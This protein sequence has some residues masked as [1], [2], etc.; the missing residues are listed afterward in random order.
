MKKQVKAWLPDSGW[1][2]RPLF[3]GMIAGLLALMSVLP[4]Q[5][6]IIA[7]NDAVPA[8]MS[9]T[10]GTENDPS[11]Y[12][13]SGEE[14]VKNFGTT[15]ISVGNVA[16]ANWVRLEITGGA[17][18]WAT[19]ASSAAYIGS[20]SSS[21]TNLNNSVWVMD[22]GS[23]LTLGATRLGGKSALNTLAVVDGG[24]L[25]L[26]NE[27]RAGYENTG[28]YSTNNM[29][30]VD[31]GTLF[32]NNRLRLGY[33]VTHDYCSLVVRNGGKVI[34]SATGRMGARSGNYTD[35]RVEGE[36][37]E[38]EL[39]YTASSAISLGEAGSPHH[40]TLTIIDGG[41][42]KLTNTSGTLTIAVDPNYGGSGV[43]FAAGIF[44]VAGNRTTH[45]TYDKAW[46]WDG[47]AWEQ[48]PV[49]WTGTYYADETEAAAA[50]RPGY[51]GYTVFTG[52]KSMAGALK[53]TLLLL[54]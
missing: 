22:E 41:V 21:F 18:V 53:R 9:D 11:I 35:Y 31:G 32:V 26:N 40:N 29:V 46:L 23:S 38:I 15:L 10:T 34:G 3:G 28:F 49:D 42:V 36:G 47:E 12:R 44:A 50:G 27:L 13:F 39:A 25:T 16:G 5:A 17:Q 14:Y 33:G 7:E 8:A 51:G 6:G 4:A 20:A 1:S 37:S 48:A 52:G 45:I 2:L 43:R 54:K 19:N 30:L 24:T